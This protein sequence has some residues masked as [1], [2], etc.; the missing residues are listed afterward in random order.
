VHIA[1]PA[2][3][4]TLA[5][6][7]RSLIEVKPSGPSVLVA[8]KSHGPL[9]QWLLNDSDAKKAGTKR[10]PWRRKTNCRCKSMV[11]AEPRVVK[12]WQDRSYDR[13][14]SW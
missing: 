7:K 4:R 14:P 6:G 10:Y 5:G 3:I 8:I 9:G 12:R 2:A 11:Y 1:G 13:E